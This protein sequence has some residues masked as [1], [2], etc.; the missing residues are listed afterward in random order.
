MELIWKLIAR[1]VSRPRIAAWI[2]NRA[3]RTP[4]RHIDG[5]M[6]RW[7]VFNPYPSTHEER[8]KFSRRLLSWL[9]S[10]RVHHIL[11]EDRDEHMHDHPWTAR[12]IILDGAYVE[13]RLHVDER[14]PEHPDTVS[15]TRQRGY[16]GPIEFGSYHRIASVTPGGVWTLFIT[17]E[18]C[19]KWGF[20]VDGKKVP[21]DEYLKDGM[22]Q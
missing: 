8:L 16:T 14:W 7:W 3:K 21:Y 5:Y 1:L 2:I 17:W 19:G 11:R 18:Y 22:Q 6:N 4:Y 9:P 20:L 10:I 15:H 13:E 12:T